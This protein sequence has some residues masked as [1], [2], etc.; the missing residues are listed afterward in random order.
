VEGDVAIV[1]SGVA[2]ALVAWRLARAGLRVL[3]FEA[4]PRVDRQGAVERFRSSPDR[5]L[6]SPY[7]DLPWAPRPRLDALHDYYVQVG[8]DLF[9]GVYERRV[10]GTTWHWLGTCLRM[11]PADFRLRTLYGVGVDWPL[12]Y[13][14]LEPWYREAEEALGVAGEQDLGSPRSGPYP[15]PP[16]APTWVDRVVGRVVPLSLLPQA[17]N[18]RPYDGRPACCGAA[19]CV[20]IC[21]TGAKYDA[22]VHVARAEQ[23][24]ARLLTETVVHRLELGPDGRVWG[25]R[26]LRPDGSAGEARA[27]LYVVAAHAIETPR[28]LLMSGACPGSTALGRYLM[29]STAQVSRALTREPLYPFRGP[30]VTSG[31][32]GRRDGPFRR[33]RAAF[34]TSV[35]T[36]GWP[37]GAPPELARRFIAQG[38]QGQDL[39]R[40]LAEH[41]SRQLTLASSCEEL[42]CADNRLELDRERRDPLGLPRPRLHY[43]VDDYTLRGAEQAM[44]WHERIFAALEADHRLHYAAAADPAHLAGTCRMGRD[45]RTSVVDPDLR[46]HE[47]PNLYLVGTAVFPTCGAGTPT[48]TVAA[49]A[50]R[51]AERLRR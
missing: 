26:F 41:A 47:H 36:D 40:A 4:G 51:L 20:P 23:A 46:C 25:L 9:T 10:G 37:D 14:D 31:F 42:P 43:R 5:G 35:G 2:G 45:P 32:L 44:R 13:Q 8:P 49:L 7:P 11:L 12:S 21:P 39:R 19:S 1:G 18:S 33:R 50:L 27:A 24:G 22:A 29:G 15:M 38:L 16:V 28:L 6:A 30:Q 48:L 3:V 34:Y 17:R